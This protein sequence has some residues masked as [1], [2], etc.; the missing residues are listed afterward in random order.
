[1]KKVI[2]AATLAAFTAA[3]ALPVVLGSDDA[4]AATKKKTSE[5]MKL[6]K[7]KPTGKM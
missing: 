1:V 2:L 4:V 3:L 6:K 5:K 7:K